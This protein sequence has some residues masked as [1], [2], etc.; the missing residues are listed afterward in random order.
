[1]TFA[2]TLVRALFRG[3]LALCSIGWSA[4]ALAELPTT[5]ELV[6]CL[7]EHPELSP[8][9]YVP[10]VYD[11]DDVA[12][13]TQQIL[14]ECGFGSTSALGIPWCDGSGH[15]MVMTVTGE[16]DGS[17]ELCVI[18]YGRIRTY[19]WILGQQPT[20]D[21]LP[22]ELLRDVENAYGRE[23]GDPLIVAPELPDPRDEPK[24]CSETRDALD[25]CTA[26][27]IEEAS[28]IDENGLNSALAS[29]WWV[30]CQRS[31]NDLFL[32]EPH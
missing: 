2:R 28:R 29:A 25:A 26:C 20:T 30:S 23:T 19:P 17:A 16:G 15:V 4:E 6:A 31:C 9:H 12:A 11:C 22:V 32:G 7:A 24:M 14:A 13:H 3:F 27:C 10:I 18:D 21:N 5:C 8:D 1:M